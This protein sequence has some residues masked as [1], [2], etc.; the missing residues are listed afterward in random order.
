MAGDGLFFGFGPRKGFSIGFE[1]RKFCK[2]KGSPI[3]CQVEF[4]GSREAT[5][6]GPHVRGEF[7]ANP[8]VAGIGVRASIS[9]QSPLAPHL[10]G[11]C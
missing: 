5:K 4:N 9:F 11:M 10:H 1:V 6:I 3:D 8:D 2:N 7:P